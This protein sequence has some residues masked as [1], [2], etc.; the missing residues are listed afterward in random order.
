MNLSIYISIA[1]VTLFF[2]ILYIA[3]YV[4]L[5]RKIRKSEQYIVD[6]FLQKIAKIPAVIEVMRPYVVDANHAFDL[7]IHLH[8]ESII[9]DY[10]AIHALLEHNARINDQYSFLMKL[11]MAIPNLQKDPYFL[12]IRDYVISYDRMM[13]R[14]LPQFNQLVKKWNTFIKIKNYSIIGYI[15]PGKSIIEI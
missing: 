13:N 14:D 4:Y 9:H 12:Y 5:S 11:S 1:L 7:M 10:T 6:I 2:I 8:S 15:L 3:F